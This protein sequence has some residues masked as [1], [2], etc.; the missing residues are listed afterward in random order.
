MKPTPR[1]GRRWLRRLVWTACGVVGVMALLAVALVWRLQQGPIGIDFIRPRI[2]QAL[3]D[4]LAPMSVRLGETTLTWVGRGR[5]IEVRTANVRVLTPEGVEL[6]GFSDVGI[7]LFVPA[8][9]DRRVVPTRLVVRRTRVLL[10]RNEDGSFELGF[11]D[12]PERS[13]DQPTPGL[14]TWLDAWAAPEDADALLGR[15]AKISILDSRVIV[16]DKMTGVAWGADHVDLGIERRN[17]TLVADASLKL[18]VGDRESSVTA[19]ATYRTPSREVSARMEIENLVPSALAKISPALERLGALDTPVSGSVDVTLADATH[20]RDARIDVEGERGR[21]EGTVAVSDDGSTFS[22]TLDARQLKPWM[23]ADVLPELEP[24]SRA[25]FEIDAHVE[26]T[27]AD[28][29]LESLSLIATVGKGTLSIPELY[30]QPLVLESARIEGSVEG[31]FERIE[32]EKLAVELADLQLTGRL[33]AERRDEG[34]RGALRADAGD[35]S[36]KQVAKYWPAHAGA[37][38]REWVLENIPEG[39]ISGLALDLSAGVGFPDA[40]GFDLGSLRTT[41]R[42]SDLSVEALRPQPPVVGIDGHA[43]LTADR[44]D[45]EVYG[46]QL[47]DLEIGPSVV[48]IT[49]LAA[50]GRLS[51]DLAVSGPVDAVA[52]LL[53]A[54]PLEIVPRDLLSGLRG[55][56]SGAVGLR[57]PLSGEIDRNSVHKV[58]QAQVRNLTWEHAPL[59]LGLDVTGGSA[60]LSLDDDAIDVRG[61]VELNGVQA[62]IEYREN[63]AGGDPAR[64]V[65]AHASIDDDGLRALGLPEQPYLSG[66]TT[67]ILTYEGNTDGSSRVEA[68][69]DLHET[70][71]K[72]AAMGWAKQA[73]EPGTATVDMRLDREGT[74]SVDRLDVTAADLKTSCRLEITSDPVGLRRLDVDHLELTGTDVH[75]S[76]EANPE[77]GYRLRVEGPRFDALALIDHLK[78]R[79][80]EAT[81]DPQTTESSRDRD[82]RAF[83]VDIRIGELRIA[84]QSA[85]HDLTTSAHF[86]GERL[87]EFRIEAEVV[88]AAESEPETP[89]ESERVSASL[90]L[91][92]VPENAGHRLHFETGNLGGLI[93]GLHVSAAIQG[94]TAQL[95]AARVSPD[96]PFEGHFEAKDFVLV[97]LPALA[98][99]LELGSI[100]GMATA[101]ST[102][103]LGIKKAEADFTVHERLLEISEGGLLGEGFGITVE[104]TADFRK[105]ELD[106]RGA[107]TPMQTI[108]KVI[109]YIPL[110]GRLLTGWDREGVIAILYSV[111][112]P[113]GAPRTDVNTS[114]VLTPGITREI[115]KLA[116]DDDKPGKKEKKKKTEDR[117]D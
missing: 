96:A 73:G 12:A 24:L 65:V 104:G 44:L 23:F 87:Q 80:A 26:L 21:F 47:R 36:L 78:A 97:S 93:Q 111:T 115:H 55:N 62:E 35:V 70:V 90:S 49:D 2:E 28:K 68:T 102:E 86:D 63:L 34:Y 43:T 76:W 3:D 48:A 107:V 91:D 32:I 114:S 46:G 94:G 5:P 117:K 15:L 10:M 22:A 108:Q 92:Y 13:E 82:R 58:A 69:A 6:A 85:L 57:I 8:L 45:F 110:V 89:K 84:E 30:P 66:S 50:G 20:L 81:G 88:A 54:P 42:F 1:K 105:K 98:K 95:S 83:A 18:R 17:R 103:G 33:S 64:R 53:S 112:G 100:R 29:S 109:G 19:K 41:F 14:S 61:R 4:L 9:L 52:T 75:G 101:F 56:L 79:D 27:V 113:L 37:E 77:T 71:L 60:E 25:R 59:P 38:A 106:L 11:G 72:I 116:V 67:V 40:A 99:I 16:H 74:W 51:L 7:G 39:S 31:H